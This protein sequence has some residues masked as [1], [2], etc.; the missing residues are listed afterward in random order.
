MLSITNSRPSVTAGDLRSSI[1]TTFST[2]AATVASVDFSSAADSAAAASKRHRD[3]L[4]DAYREVAEGGSASWVGGN[5]A[6]DLLGGTGID[7]MFA[8]EVAAPQAAEAVPATSS[9][10]GIGD[11]DL[12]GFAAEWP[13]FGADSEN[14]ADQGLVAS[15]TTDTMPPRRDIVEVS[16]EPE[17]DGSPDGSTSPADLMFS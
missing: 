13:A 17:G 10:P 2:A 14:V 8:N 7:G 15:S 6:F 4:L 12:L 16:E 1:S 3:M 11:S 5:G 9:P